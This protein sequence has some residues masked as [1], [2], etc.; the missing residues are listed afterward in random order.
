[1]MTLV[2]IK[3]YITLVYEPERKFNVD[4]YTQAENPTSITIKL[5]E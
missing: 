2:N 5:E 4:F 3:N 1:M